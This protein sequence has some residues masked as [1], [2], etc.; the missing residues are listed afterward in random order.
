MVMVSPTTRYTVDQVLAMPE[1]GRRRELLG[2]ELFVTPAPALPHQV[3]VGELYLILATALATA[4]ERFRVMLSPA[5]IS[6]D[7]ETLVQPDIFVVPASE[8]QGSWV[9]CR[10]LLLTVEVLSPSTSRM[11]RVL[12]REI[13]LRNGVDEYWIVDPAARLVEVWR[14]Q[15]TRPAIYDAE[16]IWSP[17]VDVAPLTINLDAVFANLPAKQER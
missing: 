3:V 17:A 15:D 6:W 5:D 13:Y 2:G 4:K 16:L 14:Q 8:V 11:D 10:R 12:K 1:D 7:E 9:E